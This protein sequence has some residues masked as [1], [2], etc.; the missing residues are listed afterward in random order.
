MTLADVLAGPWRVRLVRAYSPYV[1]PTW[2]LGWLLA[3][4]VRAMDVDDEVAA[5][6]AVGEEAR[7]LDERGRVV[8]RSF[9]DED[10]IRRAYVLPEE[11][12]R[13]IAHAVARASWGPLTGGLMVFGMDGAG[14]EWYSAESRV[15]LADDAVAVRV[16]SRTVTADEALGTVPRYA[17]AVSL[18]R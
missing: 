15:P 7:A 17:H 13:Q 8:A 16:P 14:G 12:R 3:R 9:P 5:V 4:E 1:V 2:C 6:M 18:L 10:A 11:V